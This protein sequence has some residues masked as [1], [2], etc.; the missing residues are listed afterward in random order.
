MKVYTPDGKRAMYLFTA[1]VPAVEP[2]AR[3]LDNTRSHRALQ[4]L[5]VVRAGLQPRDVRQGLGDLL[6]SV[7]QGVDPRVFRDA[8]EGLLRTVEPLVTDEVP[9]LYIW[10]PS[11]GPVGLALTERR[12]RMVGELDQGEL[13][14]LSTG[15]E[16][17]RRGD[18]VTVLGNK[19]DSHYAIVRSSGSTLL[20]L[21][22]P[23]CG[24]SVLD[25]PPELLD[26]P[27]TCIRCRAWNV[28]YQS[29]VNA[30]A[31][32][33]HDLYGTLVEMV[34]SAEAPDDL[35][36]SD[37]PFGRRERTFLAHQTLWTLGD[38]RAASERSFVGVPYFGVKTMKAILAT[39]LDYLDT[40][41]GSR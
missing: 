41:G 18:L 7:A 13:T 34:N 20:S 2:W 14:L 28:H 1:L 25:D 30:A 5:A 33:M 4:A 8:P 39:L 23:K 9:K 36:L 27:V 35:N 26:G 10:L 32:P 19:G 17:K 3:S 16:G 22:P 15:L 29:R 6:E 21:T 38:L 31:M 24:A 40:Q 12:L 11:G 37:L